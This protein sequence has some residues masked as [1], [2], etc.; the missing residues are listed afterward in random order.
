MRA[1]LGSN[2]GYMYSFYVYL[3]ENNTKALLLTDDDH[4]FPLEM[5]GN[6]IV[7]KSTYFMN[8]GLLIKP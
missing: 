8:E 7:H 5:R 2:C 6:Q 3:T 4:G 1:N